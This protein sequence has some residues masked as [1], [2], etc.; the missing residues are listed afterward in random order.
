MLGWSVKRFAA[1]PACAQIIIAHAPGQA[2]QVQ[3][4]L[5]GVNA[6]LVEGGDTRT[7]SVRNALALARASRVLI[8]DAARPMLSQAVIDRL[9]EVLDTHHGAAPALRRHRRARA[10][11]R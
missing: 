7:G 11:R 9:I 2:D 8:H 5:D 1:D 3:A 4:C 10:I 6:E